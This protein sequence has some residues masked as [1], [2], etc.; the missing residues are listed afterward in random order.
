MVA[1]HLWPRK[2]HE[3]L[4]LYPLF[5]TKIEPSTSGT[6]VRS[7]DNL[8]SEETKENHGESSR[9]AVFP[10]VIGAGSLAHPVQR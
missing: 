4:L 2:H 3:N 7:C 8:L 6:Q 5:L 9:T 10:V 1:A